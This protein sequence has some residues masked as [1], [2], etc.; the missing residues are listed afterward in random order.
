[1]PHTATYCCHFHSKHM[2]QGASVVSLT[3]VRSAKIPNIILTSGLC[4]FFIHSRVN[5]SLRK[6]NLL[7]LVTFTGATET[8]HKPL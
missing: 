6:A 7:P 8:G 2:L 3:L 4:T 5:L 1:M